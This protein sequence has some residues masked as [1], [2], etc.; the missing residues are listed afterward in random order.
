MAK[1]ALHTEIGDIAAQRAAL[2]ARKVSAVELAQS[3]LAAAEAA[4]P[5]NAFLHISP[6]TRTL[7]GLSLIHI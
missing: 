1:P 7:F 5:L 2:A 3:A 4:A 6:R